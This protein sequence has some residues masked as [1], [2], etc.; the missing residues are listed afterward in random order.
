MTQVGDLQIPNPF[1]GAPLNIPA[2]SGGTDPV[3]TP[4]ARAQ[5]LAIAAQAGPNQQALLVE[6]ADATDAGK[7]ARIL[8]FAIG[9][10]GGAAAG[11]LACK[12][13][14]GKKKGR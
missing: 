1:G 4:E 13:F 7:H 3:P 14:A 12:L 6:M 2:P 8:H 5:M 10:V 9:G 11:F